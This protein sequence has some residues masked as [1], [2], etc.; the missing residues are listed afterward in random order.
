[1]EAIFVGTCADV[2]LVGTG[3]PTVA[4]WGESVCCFCCSLY[5]SSLCFANF[6]RSEGV[7]TVPTTDGS[8]ADVVVV[9]DGGEAVEEA[10]VSRINTEVMLLADLDAM[11][12][13]N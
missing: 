3:A 4:A 9:V 6:S 5:W 10:R 1:M 7:F 2:G 12:Q 13:N 11:A 8:M